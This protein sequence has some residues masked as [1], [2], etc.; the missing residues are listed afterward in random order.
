MRHSNIDVPDRLIL[1]QNYGKT[2][3]A[4]WSGGDF[5]NDDA[6]GFSDLLILAQNYGQSL[7]ATPAAGARRARHPR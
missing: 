4:S 6:V 5:N 3:G 7:A 2:S 1:A